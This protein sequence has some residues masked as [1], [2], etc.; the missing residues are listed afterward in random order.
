MLIIVDGQVEPGST[1]KGLY[2]DGIQNW[3][4]EGK[5]YMH[6]GQYYK[7]EAAFKRAMTGVAGSRQEKIEAVVWT[8]NY[9]GNCYDLLNHREMAIKEYENVVE[10]G[11]NYRGAVDY[12][13]KYLKK[14]FKKK[15]PN[16]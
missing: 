4:N 16:E 15:D 9:L 10:S 13:R 12:A 14:P 5:V 8:H 6:K 2:T 11:N 1:W 3:I 7:A